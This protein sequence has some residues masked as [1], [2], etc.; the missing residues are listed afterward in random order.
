MKVHPLNSN[1]IT[2]NLHIEGVKGKKL[3]EFLKHSATKYG[4][5]TPLWNTRR[6][7][8][9]CKKELGLTVSR[10][11][12][13]RFLNKMD[14]TC[15][16]VQKTYMEANP[17]KQKEWMT[18]TISEIKENVKIHH[19]ILYFEDESNISLSPV[20]GTSW[21]PR[22]KSI[23][24]RVTGKRGSVSAISAISKDG[25]LMFSLHNSGKRFKSDDII[26]FGS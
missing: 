21:S 4:F 26:N 19:A 5:E 22:G 16:R 12:I 24:A 13:W 8:I 7:E 20:M 9:L 17:K 18:K 2:D 3:I 14:Y 25:R 11:A 15:K 1:G 6:I 23:T 10:M